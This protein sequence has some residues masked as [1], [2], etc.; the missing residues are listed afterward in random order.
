MEYREDLF[1]KMQ[2]FTVK[3]SSKSSFSISA[4]T[5]SEIKCQHFLFDSARLYTLAIIKLFSILEKQITEEKALGKKSSGFLSF[6]EF[7]KTYRNSDEF[8][9]LCSDFF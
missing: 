7:L 6:Y 8:I 2:Y 9:T 4:K 5:A 3:K 1:N